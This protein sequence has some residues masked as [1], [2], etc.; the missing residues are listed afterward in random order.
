MQLGPS[1]QVPAAESRAV[2][3]QT[4]VNP[5]PEGIRLLVMLS[6]AAGIIV[7]GF[8]V[9]LIV[10]A[11]SVGGAPIVADLGT[12]FVILGIATFVVRYGYSNAKSWGRKTGLGAGV[13][14]VLLGLFLLFIPDLTTQALAVTSLAFG[15]ANLYYLMKPA[16][17]AYFAK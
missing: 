7:I 6:L 14:Y 16:T 13:V 1:N 4:I 9:F 11:S 8:G 15:A 17:K 2:V 3:R 5:R 10:I 12:I